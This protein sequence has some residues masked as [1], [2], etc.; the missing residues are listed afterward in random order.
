LN[1]SY[2]V[3]ADQYDDGFGLK[4]L[5]REWSINPPADLMA[6]CGKARGASEVNAEV[7]LRYLPASSAYVIAKLT[8][9]LDRRD[10]PRVILASDLTPEDLKLQDIVY[11]GLIDG[12]ESMRHRIFALCRYD[13]ANSSNALHDRRTGATFVS[14]TTLA[15]TGDGIHAITNLNAMKYL[16][17]IVADAGDFEAVYVAPK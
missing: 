9:F 7:T 16:Q 14:E 1:P 11:V 3:G 12:M 13:V 8:A 4:R 6:Q 5:V 10:P 15:A 2:L 17:C